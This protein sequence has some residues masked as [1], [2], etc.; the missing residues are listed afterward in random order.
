MLVTVVLPTYNGSQYVEQAIN[1]ILAQ[2]HTDLEVLVI[3]DGST[4]RTCEVITAVTDP[5]LSLI[6]Q[7]NTGVAG[8]RNAGLNRAR[9]ELVAFLDQDD[10]W[11]PQKLSRQIAVFDDPAIGLV[12]SL[13]TYV[14]STGRELG[15]SGE[16]A[17]AQQERIAAARLMPFAP[18][19]MIARA[20]VLRE[21]G[22]FD[23]DLVRTVA[24]IDDLDLVARVARTHRVVTVPERLGFY[25]VHADAGTFHKFYE[26]QRGTRFLQARIASRQAGGDLSWANWSAT[27]VDGRDRR[28]QEKARFLYRRAGF[29][30]A[31]DQR[32]RGLVDL[33]QAGALSPSYTIPRLR[34]QLSRTQNV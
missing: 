33:A 31:S 15:T 17:D 6:R 9:G 11:L 7:A 12:G 8:A 1:S 18:S 19:S 27:T 22:G 24:P 2:T 10:A 34:R 3:D 30:I 28:R 16:I 20:D 4:D 32:L 23:A 26:M 14:G 29:R 25:R 5:R 21:L 13:M